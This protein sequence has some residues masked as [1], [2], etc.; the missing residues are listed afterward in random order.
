MQRWA[1]WWRWRGTEIAAQPD[2]GRRGDGPRGQDLST[3]SSTNASRAFEHNLRALEQGLVNGNS[4]VLGTVATDLARQG[5]GVLIDD[6]LID[7]ALVYTLA[8]EVGNHEI[9]LRPCAG[10][11]DSCPYTGLAQGPDRDRRGAGTGAPDVGADPQGGQHLPRRQGD[12]R[13]QH[14]R[15]WRRL[16]GDRGRVD[17]PARRHRGAGGQ[18]HGDGD[19]ADARRA[20]HA[21]RGHPR[22]VLDPYR[23]RHSRRQSGVQSGPEDHAAGRHRH[24]RHDRH[25]GAHP[26]RGGAADHGGQRQVS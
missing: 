7:R 19:L 5:K 14:G 8:A 16:R 2:R 10:T 13:L 17:R 21:A 24:R 20:L 4:F 22:P 15:L 6:V 18:G 11:G 23:Q 9:G 3:R 1:N 25:G 12:D 26:P